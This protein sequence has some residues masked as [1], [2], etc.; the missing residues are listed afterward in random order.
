MIM[1]ENLATD[2][3]GLISRINENETYEKRSYDEWFLEN[4]S[5]SLQDGVSVLDIG[6]G[7]GKQALML[8]KMF[9]GVKFTAVDLSEDSLTFVNDQIQQ[10]GLN[11]IGTV[12][13]DIDDTQRYLQGSEFDVIYSSYA[14]YYSTSM[15]DRLRTYR[16]HLSPQGKIMLF[17]PGRKSNQ[18]IISLINSL[19]HEGY[20]SDYTDFISLPDVEPLR[21][22]YKIAFREF[23]NEVNFPTFE[24]FGNWFRSSELSN[25]FPLEKLE[26]KINEIIGSND[27]FVLTKQTVA[28]LLDV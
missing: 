16:S 27:G 4:L 26:G 22:L 10:D 18:E 12:L 19:T 23:D 9:P 5:P 1:T 8:A 21:D 13:S 17:G 11:N 7:V 20:V 6:C 25:C 28:L 2:S 24:S 3:Q 15:V 14:F